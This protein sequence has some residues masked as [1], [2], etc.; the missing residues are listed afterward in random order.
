MIDTSPAARLV[1]ITGAA[2]ALAACTGDD[3]EPADSSASPT[4]ATATT[5]APP[6]TEAAVTSAPS[7]LSPAEQ[8]AADIEATVVGFVAALDDAYEGGDIEG[9]YP[10]SRDAARDTWTTQLMSYQ[11]QGLTFDGG[12]PVEVRDVEVNGDQADVTACLD[13]SG[14]TVTDADG[15]DITPDRE[16]GDLIIND[17]VLER[18]DDGEHGWIVVDDISRS[19]PCDG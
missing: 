8:D 13:Y 6:S 14:T 3:A 5:S 12:V 15:Q 18:Y 19:E 11:E 7:S 1:A 4:A 10:W 16:A 17:Y 9:I 2:L